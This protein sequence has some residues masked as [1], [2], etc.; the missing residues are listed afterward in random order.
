MSGE[1]I[2][3]KP[4]DRKILEFLAKNGTSTQYTMIRKKVGSE[5]AIWESVKRLIKKN[6]IELKRE[7]P[8]KK[9]LGKS[10]KYYGLTFS[11][12]VFTIKEGLLKP[13]QAY[14]ARLR[15]NIS[16]P[17]T[18]K[19]PNVF[20]N[21]RVKPE[22]ELIES[23]K[24]FYSI[25]EAVER[26]MPSIF[27]RLLLMIDAEAIQMIASIFFEEAYAVFVPFAANLTI[28]LLSQHKDYRSKHL[29]NDEFYLPDGTV[30]KSFKKFEENF[31]LVVK[32]IP[33]RLGLNV[34]DFLSDLLNHIKVKNN[35]VYWE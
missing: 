27:Y 17:Y 23:D 7:E 11:G 29:K 31:S 20:P 28:Y 6:Y 35:V 18:Y 30:V 13:S 22:E 3:L 25:I 14:E 12:L 9:I 4:I 24:A 16:L 26:T 32:V 2:Q 33:E 34:Q 8:F 1:D 10:K 5:S 15:N 21:L 19:I